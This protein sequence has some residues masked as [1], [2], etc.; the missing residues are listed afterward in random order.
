MRKL[1][2]SLILVI[3]SWDLNPSG[4]MV[5]NYLFTMD[6]VPV[7]GYHCSLVVCSVTIDMPNDNR[8]HTASVKAVNEWGISTAGN[9]RF[10]I[11]DLK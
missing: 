11:R 8:N 10:K 2:L 6:S 4:E 5:T 3:I 1:I 7:A 9:F